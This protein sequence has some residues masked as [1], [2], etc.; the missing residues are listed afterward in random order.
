M[1][2]AT[3][4]ARLADEL[5]THLDAA[6]NLAHWLL[7]NDA[8]A[9]DVVQDAFVRALRAAETFRG[10]SAKSWFLAIVRNVA[11]DRLRQTKARFA[12]DLDDHLQ[13]ACDP[14][15]FDPQAILMRAA[16]AERVRSAIEA[17]PAGIREVVVLREMEA[18]SYKEIAGVIAAPIGTVM[19]RLARGREKLA[20]LLSDLAEP[21]RN[22]NQA[23]NAA[24]AD[25]PLKLPPKV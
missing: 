11:F 19:S 13:P 14:H 8:D 6:N 12:E 21:V 15:M 10:G 3:A 9:Q 25:W 23:S 2:A 5:L 17:L 16:N 4:S 20:E 18:M 7:H 1:R 22:E 24:N